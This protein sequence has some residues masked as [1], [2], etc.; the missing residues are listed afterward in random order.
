MDDERKTKT[1]LIAEL[2]TLRARVSE[3]EDSERRLKES[4]S[5]Y[6]QILDA[7]QDL[8]LVKGEHSK[9]L[10]ANKAFQD[11]Y[12]MNMEQLRG[13]IDAPFNA[14]EYTQQYM[15]DDAA[16][17]RTGK[18]VDIPEEP[19]T[20]HDG[21]VFIFNTIK[22][23]IFSTAGA[24]AMTVG[25]SRDI[26]ERKQ[27]KEALEQRALELTLVNQKL[28]ESSR[29]LALAAD[30]GS[31]L[32][33]TDTINEMLDSCTQA[34]RERLEVAQATVWTLNPEENILE[35][36]A[37]F[38]GVRG[39]SPIQPRIEIG[40]G[41]I[42]QIAMT[43]KAVTTCESGQ[44]METIA[45]VGHPLMV[46]ER[47][48]GVLCVYAVQDPGEATLTALSGV[49]D[50]IALGIDKKRSEKSLRENEKLFRQIAE[51]IRDIF[52]VA[53]PD[54]G[55][56]LYISPAYEKVFGRS[57]SELM[58]EP[59][60]FLA[61][62]KDEDRERC[63]KAM[64]EASTTHKETD[65]EFCAENGTGTSRW[66]WAR[67]FPVNDEFGTTIRMCGVAH[68]ITERKEVERRVSQF[69]SMVSH[70]L[71]TPLTSIRAALGL[72][73]GGHAGD[74]AETKELVEIARSESDRLI[75]L[76]NDILDI[77]KI[78]SNRIELKLETLSCSELVN[79]TVA[80]MRG[81]AKE[82]GVGLRVD[83]ERSCSC[84]ADRDRV[85]QVLTNLI[86]NAVK[87]SPSGSE[88]TIAVRDSGKGTVMFRVSDQGPGI[89]A[90]KQDRLFGAFQQIDSSD[91]R[92]KGG[93][94]LGLFI[95]KAIIE[96]HKG[97]I[98]FETSDGHGSTFWF[99]LAGA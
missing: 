51:N 61:S 64:Q 31:A 38:G 77:K 66:I 59:W 93:S 76:I 45:L 37:S 71:R 8:V 75:R 88:V 85:I 49:V 86:S 21:Q 63:T 12:G 15:I 6:S 98:G 54:S 55:R 16:V 62:I 78:E 18:N 40:Q 4:E 41:V 69:Y 57:C 65:F 74:D 91:S 97:E 94:G 9:I 36:A 56:F 20:R 87:F 46:N 82:S 24:V 52:W 30:V 72:I 99:E 96:R 26:T 28:T 42:G 7:T 23:P 11:F 90:D 29:L 53:E 3:L 33:G 2:Q 47:L 14:P 48:V 39:G 34:I 84:V 83:M 44:T 81:I 73:E 80:I 92:A 79:A 19:V 60:S 25:V 5:T 67:S 68:D 35:L 95:S 32:T 50:S 89:P 1:E 13:I 43:R 70:E 10:Y 17:Y 27:A 22:S 58:N